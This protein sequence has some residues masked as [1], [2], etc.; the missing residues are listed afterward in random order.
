MFL[1]LLYDQISSLGMLRMFKNV[2]KKIFG[3]GTVMTRDPPPLGGGP[4]TVLGA[5]P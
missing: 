3:P 5:A 2:F 4:M 1:E